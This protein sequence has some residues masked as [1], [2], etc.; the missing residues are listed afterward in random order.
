MKTEE[1]YK[2]P[3]LVQMFTE[4][5]EVQPQSQFASQILQKIK[6]ETASNSP[7]FTPLISRKAWLL[8]TLAGVAM[9]ITVY[10]TSNTQASTAT[11][12]F[13]LSF[14]PDFTFIRQMAEKVAVSFEF[15]PVMRTSLLAM[16]VFII[17][18]MIMLEWRNRSIFK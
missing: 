16:A 1:P 9:F 11:E 2:D 7:V 4:G 13:G 10:F 8:L 18:Q 6:A 5:G 15:S 12:F 3:K 17:I 14:R